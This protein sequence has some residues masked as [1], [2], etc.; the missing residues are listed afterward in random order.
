VYVSENC[1]GPVGRW[2]ERPGWEQLGQAATG[3]S[4]REGQSATGGVPRPAPV[5]SMI[6]ALGTWPRTER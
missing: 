4:Y 1:Y 6:T 3:M 5:E 2:S